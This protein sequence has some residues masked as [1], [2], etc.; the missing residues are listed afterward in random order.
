MRKTQASCNK[1]SAGPVN[2]FRLNF[3]T[4]TKVADRDS[5]PDS[6]GRNYGRYWQKKPT[7]LFAIGM[8]VSSHN[9]FVWKMLCQKIDEKS[10]NNY[11]TITFVQL[12]RRPAFKIGTGLTIRLQIR[13]F[14]TVQEWLGCRFSVSF[15]PSF[16][17]TLSELWQTMYLLGAE[18]RVFLPIGFATKAPGKF[19]FNIR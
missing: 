15:E 7:F 6:L 2:S 12:R 3:A 4:E 18:R 10:E 13:H 8:S 17:Q 9:L 16:W 1:L 5:S 14:L 11:V 19:S